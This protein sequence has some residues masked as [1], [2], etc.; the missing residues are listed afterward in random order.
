MK[1]N[2]GLTSQVGLTALLNLAARPEGSKVNSKVLAEE[3]GSNPMYIR[4]ILFNLTK[5]GMLASSKGPGGGYI[6]TEALKNLK[7]SEIVKAFSDAKEEKQAEVSNSIG[8]QKMLAL[9]Q[10]LSKVSEPILNKTI[11]QLLQENLEI[12]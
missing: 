9:Q 7:V 5:T 10:S 8:S 1:Y 2:I 4:T 3:S 12:N 11:G 6:S